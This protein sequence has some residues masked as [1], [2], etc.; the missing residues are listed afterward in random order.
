VEFSML[1]PWTRA[2]V[3]S[4]FRAKTWSAKAFCRK[5]KIQIKSKPNP[6]QIQTKPKWN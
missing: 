3:L 6:N 1:L 2:Q 5:N 4:I